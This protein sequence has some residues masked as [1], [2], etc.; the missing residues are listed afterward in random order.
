MKS[1]LLLSLLAVSGTRA[2]PTCGTMETY[3]CEPLESESLSLV[4]Q[5]TDGCEHGSRRCTDNSTDFCNWG[6]WYAAP[7]PEGT[8]CLPNDWECVTQADYER[9]YPIFNSPENC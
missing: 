6:T 2:V 4:P 1:C 3:P 8:I 5:G 9:L 7:C